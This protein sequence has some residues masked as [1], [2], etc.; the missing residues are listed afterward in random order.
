[1]DSQRAEAHLRLLVEEELRRPP[2]PGASAGPGWAGSRS[3]W[4]PSVRSTTRSPTGSWRTS[5]WLWPPGRLM[6]QADGA[7]TRYRYGQRPY[8]A[9]RPG[10]DRGRPALARYPHPRSERDRRRDRVRVEVVP[11][12]S[13]ATTGIE[14]IATGRSARARAKLP[15]HWE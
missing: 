2:G 15:L 4:R 14:V 6:P 5:T 13:R 10:A 12:L 1:V 7:W 11:P 3:C 9:G 8:G